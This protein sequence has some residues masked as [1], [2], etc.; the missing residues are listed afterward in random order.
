MQFLSDPRRRSVVLLGCG[1]LLFFAL[2]GTL[3]TVPLPRVLMS[4][5]AV[6]VLN[7][8]IATNHRPGRYVA[9]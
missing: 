1:V 9:Q 2:L 5:L 4:V 3:L 8:V 7:L 6:V